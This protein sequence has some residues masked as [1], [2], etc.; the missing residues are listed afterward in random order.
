MTHSEGHHD[1]TDR[2][3]CC[4]ETAMRLD[5]GQLWGL[6]W[7]HSLVEHWLG[8]GSSLAPRSGQLL[9]VADRTGVRRT[10]LVRD[11]SPGKSIKASITAPGEH[12]A[13]PGELQITVSEHPEGGFE[14]RIVEVGDHV[15]AQRDEIKAY[16]RAALE[17]LKRI[18]QQVRNRRDKPRQAV[19]VIHGIGEQEPGTTLHSL[20]A[21]GLFTSDDQVNK[22]SYVKPDRVSGSFELR[23]VAFDPTPR[24]AEPT[25]PNTDVYELYWA[26]LMR[27]TTVGQVLDW[28][29]H[30]LL[31]RNVPRP[32]VPLWGAIWL[33]ILAI[34]GGWA[35]HMLGLWHPP[36]WL[37]VGGVLIGV[38]AIFWRVVG[39]GLVVNVIGDAARYLSPRPGNVASRQA[40]RQAG[41]DLLEAL[42]E[43]GR[44]DRI[45]VLGHSLGSVIAYDVIT[46]SWLRMHTKHLRPKKPG[47]QPLRAVENGIIDPVTAVP[48]QKLQHDAWKQIRR[49]TQPW[50]VTDLVTVGSPLTYA[51]FLMAA[52]KPKFNAA[53][54]DKVLPTCPPRTQQKGAV[55][56]C[57][58]ER[59]YHPD[60][61][62]ADKT[63]TMFDH[64]APFAVT[65]WTNLFFQTRWGGLA[66]DIIGGPVSTQFG[67][68]VRDIPLK[69]PVRWFSH[70]WYWRSQHDK[71]KRA[72][73][74]R[75]GE[76]DRNEHLS[77][78]REALQLSTWQELRQLG[79]EIPA[80]VIAERIVGSERTYLKRPRAREP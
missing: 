18:I 68:W 57:S 37:R 63:F 15:A 3:E 71:P 36:S 27:D 1:R 51:D 16:W 17:R 67:S 43:R 66:G 75:K 23:T 56:R 8:A 40:I 33:T 34:F 29:R 32:L 26:H 14:V 30:L 39:K 79:Q 12:T 58:Y 9:V 46:Y 11:V 61:E 74:D 35:A 13:A 69:N 2:V 52:D 60:Y 70:T 4:S 45:V 73:C 31:R 20:V 5:R 49:N 47:F 72:R 59:Q 54:D 21:S 48:A 65:R 6:M 76:R 64:G 53:K 28:F 24:Q 19:I 22:T 38:A 77:Q 10:G 62:Y 80:Y 55:Q 42:H 50:L 25:N 7:R 41:V 44:Y 78:L